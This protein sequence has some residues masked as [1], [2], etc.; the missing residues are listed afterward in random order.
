M[1]TL[2]GI[3]IY[4]LCIQSQHSAVVGCR[5]D[6]VWCCQSL[7]CSGPDITLCKC[8]ITIYHREHKWAQ[9]KWVILLCFPPQTRVPSSYSHELKPPTWD[10][11]KEP[12]AESQVWCFLEYHDVHAEKFS[13]C[14]MH[15]HLSKS[16]GFMSVLCM[17]ANWWKSKQSMSV[18]LAKA[19]LMLMT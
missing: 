1:L 15:S 17:W 16:T 19:L 12:T 9:D 3:C 18:A 6:K 14:T 2:F 11:F 13:T 7:S 10:E 4:L 5:D 8:Y